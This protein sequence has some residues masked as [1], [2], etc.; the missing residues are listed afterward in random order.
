MHT[1][2]E[3]MQK[4]QP[5]LP[6]RGATTRLQTLQSVA[7]AF[8]PTLPARGATRRRRAKRWRKLHFNPRSPHGERRRCAISI[9]WKPHFNPRSPHGER[10]GVSG[11]FSDEFCDF[12]PRSPHGERRPVTRP[13]RRLERISTHA[14]RTGS[15]VHGK[16]LPVA[17][18]ISTHAPRTGSD[19]TRLYNVHSGMVFQPTLPARGATLDGV[20]HQPYHYISTHAPRTGSDAIVTPAAAAQYQFQ[21]TLPARGATSFRQPLRDGKPFQP[22]LPAR[23]ATGFA[24]SIF[25]VFQFQPT[26]PARG[27]TTT[28]FI[29]FTAENHFNPRS[30]H[31]ERQQGRRCRSRHSDISTHAPRTGSDAETLKAEYNPIEFQPTLPARG[32]TTVKPCVTPVLTISTHAPRT[33]SDQRY[34]MQPQDAV[35]FNPRSP[36]GERHNTRPHSDGRFRFQPTL[37]ARGA[38]VSNSASIWRIL[39]STHAPRTGSDGSEYTL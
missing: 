11:V 5:T 37:P 38:T 13:I 3:T 16:N 22:T 6:A 20:R 35:N 21:P 12:N 34:S 32:A 27:A 36:H 31:G 14:P 39:I 23:G 29:P 9:C 26:L 7:A 28:D 19:H 4:F 8:Q 10:H 15:D 2:L 25:G 1:T 24:D 17:V 33:G 18:C 30:P